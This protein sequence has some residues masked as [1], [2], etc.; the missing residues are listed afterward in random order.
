MS[1][2]DKMCD[3]FKDSKILHH[4]YWIRENGEVVKMI[5]IMTPLKSEV[6]IKFSEDGTLKEVTY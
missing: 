6:Y 4:A 1:D 3:T 2:F 5:K